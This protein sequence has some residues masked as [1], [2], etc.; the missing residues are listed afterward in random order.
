MVGVAIAAAVVLLAGGA[1][2]TYFL[3]LKPQ[4]E[5]EARLE[6]QQR[7]DAQRAKEEEKARLDAQ[8]AALAA[9]KAAAPT[10]PAPAPGATPAPAPAPA[11]VA[12]APQPPEPAA[13]GESARDRH[14]NKHGKN[15]KPG[16]E[17]PVAE[18]TPRATPPPPTKGTEDLLAAGDVDKEFAKELEGGSDGKPAKHG[19]YI[20]PPPGQ[21]DLPASLSQADIVGAVSA[22]REA[23][24]RC[25][26]EQKKRDPSATGTVVMRWRIRP[27]GRSS[28]IAAKGEDYADSPLAGCFKGQIAKLHFGA[29][30]GAQM[31]PIEFPFSF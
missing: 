23:F 10:P 12:R 13:R 11:P 31:A 17:A 14:G 30:R 18:A 8:A 16:G 19:P 9:Q 28:D 3:V 27:D 1:A 4:H 7:L 15:G 21:G 20:P 2:A 26:Q 22:H 29:Y 6:Q 25:V 24:A 5:I